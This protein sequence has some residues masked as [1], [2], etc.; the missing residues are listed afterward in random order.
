MPAPA[1]QTG[2]GIYMARPLVAEAVFTFA[3]ASVVLHVATHRKNAGNSYFGL[4]IGFTVL[5]SAVAIGPV[6]GAALNPAV[7][8]GPALSALVTGAHPPMSNVLLYSVGPIAGA[9]AA[10]LVFNVVKETESD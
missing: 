2:A 4:A 1:P 5:A 6:T 3:L 8:I 10:A 9:I 7:G